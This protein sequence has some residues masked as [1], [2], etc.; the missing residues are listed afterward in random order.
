MNEK[1]KK[2]MFDFFNQFKKEHLSDD[3]LKDAENKS[4]FLK[5]QFKNF[6]LMIRM[7]RDGLS[8]R[9]QISR[10]TLAIIGGAIVYVISPI[11]AIPDFIP[12]IGYGDDIAVIA[13]VMKRLGS[14]IERYKKMII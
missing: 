12:G 8:G 3:E 2:T 1:T 10:A 14:E 5:D 4:C 6:L 9:Y 13:F 11:D 7:F